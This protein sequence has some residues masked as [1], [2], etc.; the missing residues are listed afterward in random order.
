M[1]STIPDTVNDSPTGEVTISGSNIE[2]ETLT[3]VSTLADADG[4]GT[5]S[6]QWLADGIAISS[7]TNSTYVLTQD[8]VGKS[9]TVSAS[10]TDDL[11]TEESVSSATD[12]ISY[13]NYDPTG[14]VTISGTATQGETLTVS[15]TLADE[16]GIG[17]ISYQ[18]LADGI[19]ISSAT[20]ST[21]TLTQDEVGK[22][23][24]VSASYT[25][26]I[27][28]AESVTS[29]STDSIININDAPTG[30]VTISGTATQGET[31]TASNIL[32]DEDGIGTISYQWQPM[33][34]PLAVQPT[35]LI[36]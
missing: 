20:E 11:G 25:D 14:S 32:A 2:G 36:L 6:Y 4:I 26:E 27:G 24:T 3:A 19:A 30:S 17:T 28:T 8:E 18:W 10:Y 9:I 13:L 31:L 15:N 16:N 5:L 7:A 33:E 12:G 29:S 22:S 23:I 34:Q 21:Y 35:A 1:D